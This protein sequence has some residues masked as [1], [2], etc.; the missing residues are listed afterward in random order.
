MYVVRALDRRGHD[1]AL[2]PADAACRVRGLSCDHA[3]ERDHAREHV[4]GYG[5]DCVA[6]PRVDE[7]ECERGY[8]HEYGDARANGCGCQN[9]CGHGP[10]RSLKSP[11]G[12][13]CWNLQQLQ[14][15]DMEFVRCV[16]QLQGQK[17]YVKCDC[18]P[19]DV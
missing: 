1:R 15:S 3:R 2:H 5:G 17:H 13:S 18:G 9:A 16:R 11:I 19:A 7:G 6:N 12:V 10:G 14:I 4:C 8:A